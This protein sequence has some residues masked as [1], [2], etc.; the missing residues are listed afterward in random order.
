MNCATV[1]G[2]GTT[3]KNN[4][5]LLSP[6]FVRFPYLLYYNDI[7]LLEVNVDSKIGIGVSFLD[8]K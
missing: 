3:V 1:K 7:N 5:G 2:I 6:P 8:G 4:G